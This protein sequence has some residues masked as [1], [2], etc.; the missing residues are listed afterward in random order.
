[1]RD[2]FA[3]PRFEGV[4]KVLHRNAVRLQGRRLLMPINR[5]LWGSWLLLHLSQDPTVGRQYPTVVLREVC[6]QIWRRT[7]RRPIRLEMANG[8]QIV[9]PAWS[10]MAG[11]TYAIGFHEP[12]EELFALAYLRPGDV[13]V[14]VGAN[15]GIFSMLMC[16]AGARVIA[17]EPGSRS[18]SDFARA[19]VHNPSADVTM[20]PV[21]LSNAPG[22]MGLTMDREAS[23]HLTTD[24]GERVEDVEVM[25]LDDYMSGHAADIVFVKIDAEGFD[26]EVLQGAEGLL[27]AQRPVLM[28]ETWGPPTVRNWLE[29]RDYRIYRYAFETHT[30]HEYPRAHSSAANILAIHRD[31]LDMVNE[32]LRTAAEPSLRLPRIAHL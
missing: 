20:V 11:L 22:R 19:L 26:L 16:A 30:L 23:N 21:A 17:F 10:Q 13:A 31:A 32:R 12:R 9:L 7:I 3:E 5:L 4:G 2:I 27:G 25:R 14:D 24:T 6:W 15:I 1:M 18:R 29:E 8:Y 28:V